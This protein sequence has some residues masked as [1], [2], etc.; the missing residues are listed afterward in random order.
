MEWKTETDKRERDIVY[1]GWQTEKRERK[2]EQNEKKLDKKREREWD[3]TQR[4]GC[5]EDKRWCWNEMGGKKWGRE[6]ENA[7]GERQYDRTQSAGK[8]RRIKKM[9]WWR[10]K[11]ENKK[12]WGKGM[13]RKVN[14]RMIEG[15]CDVMR[16]LMMWRDVMRRVKAKACGLAS[17]EQPQSYTAGT[18]GT[19]VCQ[20]SQTL[21]HKAAQAPR[22]HSHTRHHMQPASQR[23][24]GFLHVHELLGLF[25]HLFELSSMC[26][27]VFRHSNRPSCTH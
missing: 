23:N 25:L 27:N 17:R 14:I 2:W 10:W 4:M 6:S 24:T 15:K 26:L 20:M 1:A 19:V 8:N 5:G 18:A 22:P 3:V 7:K 16:W 11:N 9:K 13:K 21:S 12:R